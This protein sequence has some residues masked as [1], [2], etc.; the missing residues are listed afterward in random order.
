MTSLPF[1]FGLP[2]LAI[3][4]YKIGYQRCRDA[5]SRGVMISGG[6]LTWDQFLSIRHWQTRRDV[7]DETRVSNQEAIRAVS[8]GT[9]TRK[10]DR[11]Y[12]GTIKE[13]RLALGTYDIVVVQ[14]SDS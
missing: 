2:I 8:L 7:Y 11:T 10:D 9:I 12:T 5:T 14:G 13:P 4:R 1:L 6:V 3:A